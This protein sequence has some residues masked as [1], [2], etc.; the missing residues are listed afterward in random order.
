MS[1]RRWRADEVT[2]RVVESGGRLH[3]RVEAAHGA[4][5]AAVTESL[6]AYLPTHYDAVWRRAG[7]CWSVPLSRRQRLEQWLDAHVLVE[8][9]I[10]EHDPLRDGPGQHARAG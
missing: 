3:V 5:G 9:V 1:R 8:A 4:I 10:W 7:R 2:V 6:R